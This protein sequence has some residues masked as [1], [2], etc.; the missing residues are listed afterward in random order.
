MR[1][2]CAFVVVLHH[3]SVPSVVQ[4]IQPFYSSVFFGSSAVTVFFVIS[5]FCIHAPNIGKTAIDWP[6]YFTRRY[7]RLCLPL[8]CIAVIGFF[9]NVSYHPYRGWVTWSLIC[10]LVYYSAYPAV[11]I[12]ARQIGWPA[13][14]VAS[15]GVGYFTLANSAGSD[16]AT[17]AVRDAVSFFPAWLLGCVVAELKAAKDRYSTSIWLLR[18][19]VLAIST[20]LGLAHYS[21]LAPLQWTMPAF[22]LVVAPWLL[23]ESYGNVAPIL[24]KLGEWSYS[25]YLAHPAAFGA[26]AIFSTILPGKMRW[27]AAICFALITAYIYYRLVEFPSHNLARRLSSRRVE[28]EFVNHDTKQT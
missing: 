6:A 3:A 17:L 26:F 7:V 4:S 22:A 8:A 24:A 20:A 14:I 2:I 21:G 1:F 11:R 23:N 25:L 10:E 9:V 15:Y 16:T 27:A 19:A 5:G 28:R 12:I 13:L 18:S